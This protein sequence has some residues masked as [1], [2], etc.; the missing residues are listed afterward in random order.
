MK[1]VDLHF[2]VNLETYNVSCL[3]GV[4][5]DKPSIVA[6][7]DD[8]DEERI[9]F[10]ALQVIGCFVFHAS[11]PCCVDLCP[12]VLLAA[13]KRLFPDGRTSFFPSVCV[14]HLSSCSP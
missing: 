7:D 2:R 10:I 6:G 8:D 11:H 13:E 4:D 3:C 5:V 1:G 14:S 9:I 12:V